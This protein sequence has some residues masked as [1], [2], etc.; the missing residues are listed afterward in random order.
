VRSFP[1]QLVELRDRFA[2][3]GTQLL[4]ASSVVAASGERA[5]DSFKR[6]FGALHSCGKPSVVHPIRLCEMTIPRKH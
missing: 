1:D 3:L 6:S 2:D 4:I 5:L